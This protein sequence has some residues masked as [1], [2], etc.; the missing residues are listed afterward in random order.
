M[1]LKPY[2]IECARPEDHE[3][4]WPPREKN[5]LEKSEQEFMKKYHPHPWDAYLRRLLDSLLER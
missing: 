2:K 4:L 5:F 3:S 1:E